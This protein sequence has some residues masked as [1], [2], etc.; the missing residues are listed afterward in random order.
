MK[1][2]RF[3][4]LLFF[5][6]F[7]RS[8]VAFIIVPATHIFSSTTIQT[9]YK[10]GYIGKNIYKLYLIYLKYYTQQILSE[11]VERNEI[12][13]RILLFI[14]VIFGYRLLARFK[15]KIQ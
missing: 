7:Q 14:V 11:V 15:R 3:N 2:G 1:N 5:I 13:I 4:K 10:C 8:L 9:Q 12:K 6:L